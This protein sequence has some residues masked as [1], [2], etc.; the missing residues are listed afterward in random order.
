MPSP[1]WIRIRPCAGSRS[2]LA[3]D[4]ELAG[5]GVEREE[6]AGLHAEH[7][8]GLIEDE[9][10]GLAHL[11][12]LIDGVPGLQQRLRLA[13]P[14][15]ALLEEPRVLDGDA[16]LVR[17]PLEQDLVARREQAGRGGKRRDHPN[18]LTRHAEGDGQHGADAL[19]LVHVAPDGARVEGQVVGPDRLAGGG[20]AADD[21]LSHRHAERP[22][23]GS[24]EPVGRDVVDGRTVGVEQPDPAA[25]A[26]HE[27]RDR[28]ADG[29]EHGAEIEAGGDELARAVERGQLLGAAPDL[30]VEARSLDGGG[31]QVGDLHQ[32]LDV[33]I[34]EGEGRLMRDIKGADQ[35]ALRDQRRQDRRPRPAP[36]HQLPTPGR[37]RRI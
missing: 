33:G 2:R 19:L 23:F 3:A 10:D 6:A 20:G 14:P 27:A 25:G 13:R 5:R 12:A 21:A 1:T 29:L 4:C 35:L 37:R 34:G 8:A 17:E 32:D 9:L 31:E 11:Q 30:G 24:A 36:R 22:P 18:D 15:L 7:L 16:G 28:P 26:A